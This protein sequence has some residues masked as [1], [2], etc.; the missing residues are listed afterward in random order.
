MR[1]HNARAAAFLA[2]AVAFAPV[3]GGW[4]GVMSALGLLYIIGCLVASLVNAVK[5]WR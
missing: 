2:L 1:D 3:V 4:H 5:G